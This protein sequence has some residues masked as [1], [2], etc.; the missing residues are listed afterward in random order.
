MKKTVLITGATSGIGFEF[1][2]L[3]SHKKYDLVLVARNESRLYEI[4]RVIEKN[5]K[6][7]VYV[8]VKDLTLEGAAREVYDYVT[9]NNIGI[10][11]L[12]NNAGFG[13]YGVFAESDIER[14]SDM[15]SLN[16]KALTELTYYFVKPMIARGSGKILNLGSIASFMPGPLMA[17]Y[18]ASKAYVL[19]FTEAL[20]VELKGTGVSITALCPGPTDT[21]FEENANLTTTGLFQKFKTTTPRK[22]ARDGYRA[23]MLKQTFTVP[24]IMNKLV[25]VLSKLSPKWITKKAVYEMQKIKT[26]GEPDITQ[27]PGVEDITE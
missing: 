7:R 14:L 26:A 18:Y 4:K 11:V 10:D 17:V 20:S 8:I 19:S 23:L 9:K 1:V 5:T 3:F 22:V 2:K 12:I 24:G 15:I 21:G 25:T 6:N 16:V 13:D 27:E